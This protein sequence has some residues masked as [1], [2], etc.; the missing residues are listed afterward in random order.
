[1]S[2]DSVIYIVKPIGRYF[3]TMDYKYIDDKAQII[4]QV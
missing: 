4:E 2:T 3:N 1:M